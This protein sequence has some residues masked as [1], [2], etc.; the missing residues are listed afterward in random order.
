MGETP[1]PRYKHV[2]TALVVLTSN[3][4]LVTS[5]YFFLSALICG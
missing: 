2:Q 5:N 1:V 4:K 3:F